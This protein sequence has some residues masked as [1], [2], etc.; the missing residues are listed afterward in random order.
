MEFSLDSATDA[1]RR[2]V[3]AF[4]DA[5]LI[6]LEADR[7]NYD[8]HENVR[9]DVLQAM[10]AK[11][12]GEGLWSLADAEGARRRRAVVRR[13]GR[14]LRGDEPLDLRPGGVQQRRARRRQHDGARA[15]RAPT[16]RRRAGC[17]RSSTARCAAPS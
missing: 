17:S 9:E 7:A 10:R 6:P 5:H 2:R 8:A 14:V 1:I 13:D 15:R 16:R 4:V 11:A 12:R 3:R